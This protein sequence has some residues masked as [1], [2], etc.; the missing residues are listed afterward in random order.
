MASG[1]L[2]FSASYPPEEGL[3][4]VPATRSRS[5]VT[6]GA[7]PKASFVPRETAVDRS[8]YLALCGQLQLK[9]RFYFPLPPPPL[10]LGFIS[11]LQP[12]LLRVS[13]PPPFRSI[14]G[15][16][17]LRTLEFL[18]SETLTPRAGA[19]TPYSAFRAEV[20]APRPWRGQQSCLPPASQGP[21]WLSLPSRV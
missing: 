9:A 10:K 3:D 8:K 14:L 7:L 2:A 21:S 4:A 20:G 18:D 17:D 15:T 11:L 1:S 6:T 16:Q 13:W 5:H 12:L 19:G